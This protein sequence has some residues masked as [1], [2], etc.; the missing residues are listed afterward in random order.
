MAKLVRETFVNLPA[1]AASRLAIV[2]KSTHILVMTVLF[3]M[4]PKNVGQ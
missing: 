3:C 2:R 1:R 4:R